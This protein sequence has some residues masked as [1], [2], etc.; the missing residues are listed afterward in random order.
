MFVH[1]MPAMLCASLIAL[2]QAAGPVPGWPFSADVVTVHS[3]TAPDGKTAETRTVSKIH[4][5]SLGR[6]W[7]DLTPREG[8]P[9]DMEPVVF[10]ITDPVAGVLWALETPTRVA[11]RF[12]IPKEAR[13]GF[14]YGIPYRGGV[15][16]PEGKPE[17]K[18]EP[19][20]TQ[21]M[22]GIEVVGF[23]TTI[24]RSAETSVDERWIA[25]KLGIAV[26]LKRVDRRLGDATQQLENIQREEPDPSLFLVPP[27]YH[28]EEMPL[29]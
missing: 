18:S 3:K 27:D 24:T 7:Q 28:I 19:L 17:V 14:G 5:D 23:R 4:R 29:Q 11:H 12:T 6:L 8:G 10:T 1:I 9:A 21:T 16:F 15:P 20:G 26:L 22:Q 25:N 13:A 2:G